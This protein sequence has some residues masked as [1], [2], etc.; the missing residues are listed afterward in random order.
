MRGDKIE[1][2]H[3]HIDKIQLYL[4]I[5]L[6]KHFK[7]QI[8][9]NRSETKEI[10][11]IAEK[12]YPSLSGFIDKENLILKNIISKETDLIRDAIE[13]KGKVEKNYWLK[14]ESETEDTYKLLNSSLAGMKFFSGY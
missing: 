13:N 11:K 4:K 6:D 7:S 1:I 9:K 10:I 14:N 12:K 5:E 8:E 3:E 2:G